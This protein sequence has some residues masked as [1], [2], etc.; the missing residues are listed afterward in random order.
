MSGCLAFHR[1]LPLWEEP[2][3]RAPL[4]AAQ[5]PPPY[6]PPPS[7]LLAPR[8]CPMLALAGVLVGSR[9]QLANRRARPAAIPFPTPFPSFFSSCL[10]PGPSSNLLL[11]A[12]A[13]IHS[14]FF[15]LL[16]CGVELSIQVVCVSNRQHQRGLNRVSRT[17]A[18]KLQ[19]LLYSNPFHSHLP[20]V[21]G[22]SCGSTTIYSPPREPAPDLAYVLYFVVDIQ[23]ILELPGL[24]SF[25]LSNHV[26]TPEYNG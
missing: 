8:N 19:L 21:A 10:S 14:V 5:V 1:T 6:F 7:L 16:S 13:W 26:P 18:T 11:L 24:L 9:K 17:T 20:T 23:T 15:L 12:L 25:R 22:L 3:A 2:L 4:P